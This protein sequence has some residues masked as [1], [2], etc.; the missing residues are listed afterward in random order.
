MTRR[1]CI[2]ILFSIVACVQLGTAQVLPAAITGATVDVA[3]NK[4]ADRVDSSVEK[5]ASSADGVVIRAGSD[6][7]AE[8]S[9][10]RT[11]YSDMLQK[12][13][14]SL[15]AE[16]TKQLA[17]IFSDTDAL[18]NK[19]AADATRILQLAQQ[20]TNTIPFAKDKPQV[21]SVEPTYEVFSSTRQDN[22]SLTVDGNFVNVG[23]AGFMPY[24]DLGKQ[25]LEPIHAETS[26]MLFMI[27]RSLLVPNGKITSMVRLPLVIPYKEGL[28]FKSRKESRF[29]LLLIGLP[30]SPGKITVQIK[31]PNVQSVQVNHV[32]TP[33]DNM[34][35]DRDDHTDTRCG[36]NET[37]TIEPNSAHVV[38]EHTEGSTWTNH[39][40]RLNN[41]SV[42]FWFRTE[43]HGMGTS[44]KLWWHY[45]YNVDHVL[46]QT[47][48]Q[49][50]QTLTLNWGSSQVFPAAAAGTFTV[51]FDGFDGSHQEY[52]SQDHDNRFIDISTEGGGLKI[53]A[54]PFEAILPITYHH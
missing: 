38:F 19:T 51:I 40:V 31:T 27:S 11:A 30:E 13:V 21:T 49:S 28:I 20:V 24:L 33:Q 46:P 14:G 12:T 29:P 18:E 42:C 37:D 36:P 1:S 54:R 9:N 5:A 7:D 50:T 15:D 45:E 43:H 53:A 47:Y 32:R 48:S 16:A 22:I 4:A 23:D 6:V 17:Q 44:D 39:P 52:L 26:H 41:P 8:I 3:L 34:Q 2:C 25:H 10:F 35:S